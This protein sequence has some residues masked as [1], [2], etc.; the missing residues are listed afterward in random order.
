MIE[1]CDVGVV[2]KNGVKGLS[3]ITAF[4]EKGAFILLGGPSGSGKS[5]FLKLIYREIQPS[6]GNVF[7]QDINVGQL[8]WRQVPYLRRKIGI[9]FEDFKLLPGRTVFEN[10][11]YALQVVGTPDH[12][13]RRKVYRALALVGLDKK[14]RQGVDRLSGGEQQRTSIARAIVNKPPILVADEPTGHLDVDSGIEIMQIFNTINREGTTVVVATHNLA[15]LQQLG[16]KVIFL[17]DGQYHL[18]KMKEGEK[19][20]DASNATILSS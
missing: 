6:T 5:T 10:V 16:K 11:A 8:P 9:V 7:V 15:W 3:D 19:P 18:E 17:L 13:I 12:K 14:A 4:I 1:F 2:Y 20:L